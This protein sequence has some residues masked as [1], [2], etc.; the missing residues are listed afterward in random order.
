MAF[1]VAKS[2]RFEIRE[3]RS[4]PNGPR[5][6]TLAN[7][8]ELTDEAIERAREK[9][10]KPF[11]VDRLRDAARR[12]GA[13]VAARP[14]DRAARDLIGELARG[15][16]VDPKLRHLLIDALA[17]WTGPTARPDTVRSAAE[18]VGV[19]LEQRGAALMDLLLLA[20]ALPSG[21]RKG[22]PLHFPRLDSAGA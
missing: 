3:S 5:S 11:D 19:P 18:W 9:A 12:A 1:I 4:T 20:D 16:E 22:K 15:R 8:T 6:R 13:P 7:F 10:S 2:G 21:G 14:A 17:G